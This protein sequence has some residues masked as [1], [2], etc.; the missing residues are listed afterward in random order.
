MRILVVTYSAK[1]TGGANRSLLMVIEHLAKN[2][3]HYIHV[4]VP[5]KGEF[6]AELDKLSIS[7]EVHNYK[8]IGMIN[9][10]SLIGVGRYIKHKTSFFLQHFGG[11]C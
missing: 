8:S 1:M 9:I 6:C 11:D 5:T 3:G 4:I 7:W 2:Y 10:N